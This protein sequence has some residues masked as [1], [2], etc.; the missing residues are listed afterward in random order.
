MQQTPHQS[1]TQK[2]IVTMYEKYQHEGFVH[3]YWKATPE[4]QQ[5]L[6]GQLI[7]NARNGNPMAQSELG[8]MY[9]DGKGCQ[10]DYEQA[11]HW[12]S[13]ASSQ[14]YPAGVYNLAASLEHGEGTQQ[15]TVT[16]LNYYH[17]LAENGYTPAVLKLA[18][19]KYDAIVK[20]PN[21]QLAVE[22]IQETS[23]TGN[24]EAMFLL[25]ICHEDGF[26]VSDDV[27]IAE[28]LFNDA[29][30]RNYVPAQIFLRDHH[31][32]MSDILPTMV[33]PPDQLSHHQMSIIWNFI[34]CN[35]HGKSYHDWYSHFLQIETAAYALQHP[36]S[37]GSSIVCQMCNAIMARI[38]SHKLK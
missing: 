32:E 16:A 13:K 36:R 24:P 20:H 9:A 10:I 26:H 22:Q 30:E 7:K 38:D 17:Q 28:K 12:F 27:R 6:Y 3:A 23:N 25:G 11:H 14:G 33:L 31:R 2:R 8:F 18:L 15:D 29:A 1:F 5:Y 37:S 34:V 35:A 4:T 19:F 21:P